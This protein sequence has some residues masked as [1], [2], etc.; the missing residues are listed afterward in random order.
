MPEV[1]AICS[2]AFRF[3]LWVQD[4]CMRPSSYTCCRVPRNV[5]RVL[6]LFLHPVQ[7]R[8][9]VPESEI[10]LEDLDKDLNRKDEIR[11]RTAEILL[12]DLHLNMPARYQKIF[13]V[14]YGLHEVSHDFSGRSMRIRQ[15]QR[16]LLVTP[17]TIAEEISLEWGEVHLMS[18]PIHKSVPPISCSPVCP[19]LLTSI[20][21]KR[22]YGFR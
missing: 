5:D 13:L 12:E 22:V 1:T 17:Y 21:E 18:R 11:L 19:R 15:I 7:F 20:P 4:Q 3:E 9:T 14:F 10:I 8:P 16:I 2:M 6:S